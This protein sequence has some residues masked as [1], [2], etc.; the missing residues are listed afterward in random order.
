VTIDVVEYDPRWAAMGA[1]A[2]A[3]LAAVFPVIEHIGS[4]AV[5]GLVAKPIIDLM[6][7]AADFAAVVAGEDVLREVG[8]EPGEPWIAPRLFYLRSTGGRR[9]HH[10]HVVPAETWATRN[11]RLLRDYLRRHPADAARY[12]QLKL[13]LAR[14]ADDRVDYTRAKTELIQEMVDAARAKLGLQPVPVWE[15]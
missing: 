11:Q 4:T 2:C 3:E 10:L 5:P 15:E 1:E 6:A 13:A 8:Y 7:P 12:G 14:T 9:T